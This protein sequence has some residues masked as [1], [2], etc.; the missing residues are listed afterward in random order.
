MEEKRD[1]G[2][3]SPQ[4]VQRVGERET[5]KASSQRGFTSYSRREWEGAAAACRFARTIRKTAT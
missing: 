3:I 1:N 4:I 2:D 5:R